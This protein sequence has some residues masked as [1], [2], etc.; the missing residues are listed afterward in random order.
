M[1]KNIKYLIETH[2]SFNPKDL[3]DNSPKKI[4]GQDIVTNSLYTY[5]PETK[6]KLQEIIKERFNKEKKKKK[7]ILQPYLLDIDT[8]HIKDMSFLFQ[9][10]C[11]MLKKPL[12]LDLSSW[13]TSNVITMRSMFSKCKSLISVDVSSFNTSLV[14]RMDFM[15]SECAHLKSIDLSNF[16][17]QCVVSMQAMFQNC[18][19]LTTLDISHFKLDGSPIAINMFNNCYNLV[20]C[21]IPDFSE[22]D[23]YYIRYM[24]NEC[25]ESIVP[26][27]YKEKMNSQAQ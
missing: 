6:E 26:E 5:T 21:E 13:N 7:D 11:K 12:I 17:T 23:V 27:W 20:E 19:S 22:L 15:F 9:D 8:S 10:I 2:Y 3:E 16:N 24:F 4:L 18:E 14:T 25:P 1:N